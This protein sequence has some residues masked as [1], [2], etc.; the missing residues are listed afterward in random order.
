MYRTNTRDRGTATV[1]E[2]VPAS[3]CQQ[4]RFPTDE[5]VL[6]VDYA[7]K[8]TETF[9]AKGSFVESQGTQT[10][11]YS[12]RKVGFSQNARQNSQNDVQAINLRTKLTASPRWR[13]RGRG[14]SGWLRDRE[15]QVAALSLGELAGASAPTAAEE[16]D[17]SRG[18]AR[19]QRGAR[20][21]RPDDT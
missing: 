7:T 19:Q 12:L 11:K 9:R 2:S 16:H 5:R 15:Y 20:E 17:E 6:L 18:D 3:Q 13:R 10:E 4:T 8:L 21:Q 1:Y 14:S